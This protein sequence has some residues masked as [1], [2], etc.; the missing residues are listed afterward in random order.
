MKKLI[1]A[2]IVLLNITEA[3][4][5]VV[6]GKIIDATTSEP[7]ENAK[8]FDTGSGVVVFSNS[9]GDFEIQDVANNLILEVSALG[10]VTRELNT[11]SN[12]VLTILLMRATENLSEVIIRGALI[13][14]TLQN[15]P[16]AISVLNTKDLQKIDN[17]NLA[18]VFNTVPGFYVNQGALNTTKLNIRGVG[19]RSQYSTN[20]IQAYFNG[21]PLTSG[22]GDLTIDDFD[23]ESISK[24]EL[25]KGPNSSMY[26]AGLGGVI[27]MY[28]AEPEL[29]RTQ[30]GIAAQ[31]GSFHTYKTTI[32]AAHAT[33]TTSLFATFSNLE[34][35]GYRDNGSYKRQSGLLS[36][37][38]FTENG[39]KLSFLGNFAKLKAFIPSSI[40]ENDYLNNPEKAAFTWVNSQGYESYDRGLFGVSYLHK[41][42]NSLTNLTSIFLNFRDAYEPR[43]FNILKEERVAAGARTK[44]NLEM[45]VLELPSQFSFGAEYY[46]EWYNM[47]TFENLYQEF[48]GQGSVLGK[49]LSNNEQ[50]RKY[51]NFFAQLNLELIEKWHLEAGFN[52]NTTNYSLKDLFVEDEINQSGDYTFNT[53]F[54]PRLGLS[55]EIEKGKNIY[56][57]ISHGFS[58][59]TVEETLTPEG[60][61]NTSLKP[62]TGINYEIGFKGNWFSNKLYT[63]VALY[64]IQ[65][66]NL[67]VAQRISED[68]YVG[69]NAGKTNHNGIETTLKYN[70]Y[71]SPRIRIQPYFNASFNYFEFEEFVN[72]E[73]DFS[74]NK[75]PGV[76]KS[77]FNTGVEIGVANNFTLFANLLAVGE[78]M[79]NDAN[80]LNTEN[81][82]IVDLKAQ[83]GFKLLQNLEGTISA[84]INNVL[85]EKY[86]SS[87]LPNAVG[88][89]DTAPRYYYP[90]NPR[91]YFVG[92]KVNYNF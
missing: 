65:I 15:T 41:F 47:Q 90:G 4:A 89:G 82:Q 29:N 40:N 55:Y 52:I 2:L 57:S 62:E 8:I 92:F 34:S 36:A 49:N 32:S 77:T 54:S 87:I 86:A 27:N 42:S 63:E 56:T 17:S 68:Q 64:S 13:S 20:R 80:S 24:I 48:E 25:I 81:Y 11:E 60:Q 45:S 19:A 53:Q 85:D 22:E 7:I 91:N 6:Q 16:A 30:V 28:S 5:Q 71:V 14:K 84:G 31:V 23:V 46:K 21:I 74:G 61:I 43:P 10:F 72:R 88:F 12:A 38:V 83:Y 44:F 9:K 26:G 59:P 37:S 39:N 3:T 50:D 78:I 58:T 51:A 79:L 76:P 73:E 18:Q 70:F 67:L 66:E 75:L 35:K 1:F 69:I 33:K